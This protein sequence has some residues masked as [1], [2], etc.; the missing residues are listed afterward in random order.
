MIVLIKGKIKDLIGSSGSGGQ[1]VI[2]K[3]NAP[4]FGTI[5]LDIL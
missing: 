5:S 3:K 1:E 4:F 2:F